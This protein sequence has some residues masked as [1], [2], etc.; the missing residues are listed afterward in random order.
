VCHTAFVGIVFCGTRDFLCCYGGDLWSDDLYCTYRGLSRPNYVRLFV[1]CPDSFQCCHIRVGF[2]CFASSLL[3]IVCIDFRPF[4]LVILFFLINKLGPYFFI[5][6][7]KKIV[8][9]ISWQINIIESLW[10]TILFQV[11]S[12]LGSSEL[13]VNVSGL[14][15]L[16]SATHI[17]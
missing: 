4:F 5:L 12:R 15:F 1:V 6:F 14:T 11:L 9:N 3:C 10:P 8:I 13:H 16:V 2:S 17:Y 7:Q